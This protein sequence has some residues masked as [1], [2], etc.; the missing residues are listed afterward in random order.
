MAI[1]IYL[2]KEYLKED[3][4]AAV[5]ILCHLKRKSIKFNTLVSANPD[6]WDYKNN[7]IKGNTKEIKDKNLIISNCISRINNVFVKYRLQQKELTPELLKKEYQNPSLYINFYSFME[8]AIK[9]RKG[10]ITDTTIKHHFSILNKLKLFKP[11][12]AFS[13]ITEDFIENFRRWLKVTKKNEATTTHEALKAF[14]TYVNIAVKKGIIEKSAFFSVKLKRPKTKPEYL[15]YDELKS[16]WELYI[17]NTLEWNYQVVLRGFLFC[18][19]TGL[20]LSD[21]KKCTHEWIIHDI[22]VFQPHKIKNVSRKTVKVPL[23]NK[24]KKLIADSEN[25][26]GLIFKIYAEQTLRKRIKKIAKQVGI[27]KEISWHTSRHTFGSVFIELT[28]DV[29][30]LQV[31]MG[32]ENIA[33]TMQ[34]VHINDAK[35]E[36]QMRAFDEKLDF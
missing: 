17:K 32:H 15:T 3:G 22:L 36:R 34:Y 2:N 21:F 5:Y 8:K 33:Q 28:N 35:K 18:C 10:D 1:K 16:L 13:E 19:F 27:K 29:A 26:T 25:K 30:T 4:T 12:L 6:H 31:L 20:R 14:K 23:N 9:E 24:A 11:D 7:C